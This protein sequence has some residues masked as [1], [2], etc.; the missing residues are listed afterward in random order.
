MGT[1]LP[2]TAV[3]PLAVKRLTRLCAGD[4]GTV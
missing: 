1:S 4:P 2:G 3:S